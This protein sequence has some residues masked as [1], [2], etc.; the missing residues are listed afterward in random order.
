MTDAHFEYLLRLGDNALVL[1][2]R[3]SE[4]CG[5]APVLEEDIALTNLAL[6]LVGQARWLLSHAGAIEG[7]GRSEDD[8]AF[9]RREHEFRNVLLVEQPNGPTTGGSA[10]RGGDFGITMARQWLFDTWYVELLRRLVDSSDAELAAIAAKALKEA[11]YHHRHSTEWVIRLG[12]G[13][14]ES[15]RRMQDALNAMWRFTGE[16]FVS[17]DVDRRVVEAGIG[18]DPRSLVDPWNAAIDEVLAEATLTRPPDG[19]M[20]DGGKRGEHTEHLG[21]LL[22]EMQHLQRTHAGAQW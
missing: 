22:A 4:W 3:L 12:D 19:W 21:Y 6:D 14:E 16:L 13:T 7:R 10:G 8:L 11:T 9:L 20:P 2:H 15:H 18:P 5:H 17:D 1:G